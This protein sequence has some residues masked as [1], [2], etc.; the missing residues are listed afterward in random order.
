MDYNPDPQLY[1]LVSSVV[2]TN[3]QTV[4]MI[5]RTSSRHRQILLCPFFNLRRTANCFFGNE[6]DVIYA[7]N[8]NLASRL[9]SHF[10]QRLGSEEMLLITS[11]LLR[12]FWFHSI[13]NLAV[14]RLWFEVCKCHTKQK[15]HSTDYN[16][17][18]QYEEN[19]LINI[20]SYTETSEGQ[21][22]VMKTTT[23]LLSMF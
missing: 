15:Y 17:L 4:A 14:Y 18:P 9:L 21:A 16:S 13:S 8:I 19:L 11:P 5:H 20:P 10:C 23:L 6:A 12:Y 22:N 1:F 7:G 2:L 3:C